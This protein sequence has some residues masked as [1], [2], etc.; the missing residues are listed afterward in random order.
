MRADICNII[1]CIDVNKLSGSQPKMF[2]LNQ[3]MLCENTAKNKQKKTLTHKQRRRK[4]KSH[5]NNNQTQINL[6][7]VILVLGIHAI[8]IVSEL[9]SMNDK[10]VWPSLFP[11]LASLHSFYL[12]LTISVDIEFIY[13]Y[14]HC[15][16]ICVRRWFMSNSQRYKIYQFDMNWMAHYTC[17][18][19]SFVH[20]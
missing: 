15:V 3:S 6:L 2:S 17:A 5:K 12:S 8:F 4:R 14:F 9:F 13:T 19:I 10:I 16:K 1:D 7:A 20:G 18:V 11:F